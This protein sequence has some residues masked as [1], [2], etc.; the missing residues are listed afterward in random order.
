[1][2]TV[3]AGQ[4]TQENLITFLRIE[5]D[6]ADTFRSMAETIGSQEHRDRKVFRGIPPRTYDCRLGNRSFIWKEN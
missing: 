2:L 6:L 3:V 1:M 5:V 4:R